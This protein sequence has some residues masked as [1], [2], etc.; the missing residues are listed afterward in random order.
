MRMH[1]GVEDRESRYPEEADEPLHT[2]LFCN[3]NFKVYCAVIPP[4]VE[5]GYHRHSE[6]ALAVV[7]DG[8]HLSTT[9]LGPRRLDRYMFPD[10]AGKL[11]RFWVGASGLLTGL[12]RLRPGVFFATLNK[13]YP[14]VHKVSA[15]AKNAAALKLMS[16]Q[17]FPPKQSSQTS[18]LGIPEGAQKRLS[19]DKYVV[20]TVSVKPGSSAGPF[21]PGTPALVVSLDGGLRLIGCGPRVDRPAELGRGQFHSLERGECLDMICGAR[22]S[23]HA[24]LLILR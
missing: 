9:T 11:K 21:R 23:A 4:G 15:S 16:I 17:F 7:V 20:Y 24:L 14:M 22:Q 10:P 8:G 19:T 2:C 18:L 1:D 5:T 6:D 3:E 12:V 13:G